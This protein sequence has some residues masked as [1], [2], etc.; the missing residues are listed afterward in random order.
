MKDAQVKLGHGS[1]GL[2][3]HRLIKNV[4]LKYLKNAT[5]M[6]LEDAA[7]IKVPSQQLAF[8][9]DSYVINPLFFP[10]GDI[11]KLSV[12]GTVNDLAMKGS[13]PKN[14]S[15]SL[16]LE[17]GLLIAD[18][19]K[20]LASVAR[21]ARSAGVT[22]VC[23]DT[24]VVERG[25]ADGIF[26]TT[27]GVGIIKIDLG[28]EKIRH[29]DLV[30]ISGSVGDHGI[31]IMN[32]RL[33]LKLKSR[34]KSDC[35]PLNHLTS[36]LHRYRSA[37]RCMRDPTRG[38]VAG[39]LNE[40]IEGTDLGIILNEEAIPLKKEVR[41]AAE[42]LGIDPLYIANEGK[43]VAVV[44]RREAT[45]VLSTIRRHPLGK[46]AAIIGQVVKKPKGVWLTTEIGGIHPLLQ[47]EAEGLPRIC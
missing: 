10:G 13:I 34:L 33:N 5:L 30:I 47:L 19:E 36:R 8:T 18:L 35:A 20:I 7:Q 15:F 9:T 42:I 28:K 46:R 11:G 16:I 24:K 38:G 43:F 22:V 21:A 3:S 31:V 6:R 23:G 27:S 17:E 12:C 14:L 25:K 39:V 4:I 41:G 29:G 45:N 37:L 44:A 40:M 26:I 2:L 1:G 32:E